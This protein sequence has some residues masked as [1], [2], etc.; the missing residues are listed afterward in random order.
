MNITVMKK[1]ND[2]R[3]RTIISSIKLK[4]N[5]LF[6]FF[7][8]VNVFKFTKKKKIQRGKKYNFILLN[9]NY[10]ATSQPPAMTSENIKSEP[11]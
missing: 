8:Y 9:D 3:N 2:F 5:Y 10:T 4:E 11:M 1:N 7:F 6:F